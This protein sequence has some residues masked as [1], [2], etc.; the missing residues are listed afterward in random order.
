M[1]QPL[2]SSTHPEELSK[3]RVVRLAGPAFDILEVFRQPEAYNFQHT[4]E[5]LVRGADSGESIGGIEIGPVFEVRS[6]FEELRWQR[7]SNRCQVG[8]TDESLIITLSVSLHTSG[9][10]PM[11]FPTSAITAL[12]L[13]TALRRNRAGNKVSG[14]CARKCACENIKASTYFLRIPK[15]VL[16]LE[17]SLWPSST[18]VSTVGGVSVDAMAGRYSGSCRSVPRP[19]QNVHHLV[20]SR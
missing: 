10:Y 9:F 5:W 20:S 12:V 18:G 3:N 4:V 19:Q 14:T 7:E 16:S 6:R 11:K 8:D 13:L 15:K 1:S 17:P 2:K